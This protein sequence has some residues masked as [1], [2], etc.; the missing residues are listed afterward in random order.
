MFKGTVCAIALAGAALLAS[1]GARAASYT[2]LDL[3]SRN[4]DIRTWTDG[5]T[6]IP[7][8]PST[9]TW[10][11]VPFDLA[12]DGAG[13]TVFMSGTL[14]IP[15]NLFGISTANTIVN[16]S[17]GSFGSVVGSV[18]FFGTNGAY[19]K[20]DLVEGTNVRDHY[21]GGYN[22]IIDGVSAVP[23][24]DNGSS[25]ARLD[26]Q[27]YT[28]PAVFHAE[29]LETIRFVGAGGNPQGAPFIAAAS[30]TAVPEP[31]TWA[32]TLAGLVLLAGGFCRGAK[33]STAKG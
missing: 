1:S 29:T 24:F 7:L 14:D 15:V 13:N 28:L 4:A 18:E 21:A 3:P 5:G 31:E 9:Q 6:Y 16:S 33:S 23:A 32:L 8:F 30:V 19:H 22:N 2:T 27:I 17:W 12:A 10:N 11:G 26:M 25:R 20:V